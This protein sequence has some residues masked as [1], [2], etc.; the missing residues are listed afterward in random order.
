MQTIYFTKYTD[1]EGKYIPIK[2]LFIDEFEK[3]NRTIGTISGISLKRV[4]DTVFT[5]AYLENLSK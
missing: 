1:I 4:D 3:G 5:K 2:F